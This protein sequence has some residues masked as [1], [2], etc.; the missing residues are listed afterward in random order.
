MSDVHLSSLTLN[1]PSLWIVEFELSRYFKN[2]HLFKSFVASSRFTVSYSQLT[3][4]VWPG[5][6]ILQ[7]NACDSRSTVVFY[8][9][10]KVAHFW[11][12]NNGQQCFS[13]LFEN[14]LRQILSGYAQQH[15]SKERYAVPIR[16][17]NCGFRR[18]TILFHE[19]SWW[20]ISL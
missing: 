10:P 6:R 7:H 15:V 1:D 2:S 17:Q 14:T 12:R 16:G 13:Q 19:H 11:S 9:S 3:R 4:D 20:F 18:K 5:V 8:S